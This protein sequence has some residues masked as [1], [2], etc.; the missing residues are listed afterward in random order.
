MSYFYVIGSNPYDNS[1]SWK[2]KGNGEWST[3]AENVDEALEYIFSSMPIPTE[4]T[5]RYEA[6][7][8]DGV[9]VSRL[10]SDE[11]IQVWSDDPLA[12]KNLPLL[13][14]AVEV[15]LIGHIPHTGAVDGDIC[16]LREIP[17]YEI[18]KWLHPERK[19]LAAPASQNTETKVLS[20]VG[21]TVR[22]FMATR[23][24]LA[25]DLTDKRL[26]LT[27]H[28]WNVEA[29]KETL[30]TQMKAMSEQIAL[31]ETYLHGAK[32]K[33]TV[34]K[35]PKGTGPYHIFQS[36]QFLNKEIALLANMTD[37]DFTDMEKLDAWLVSSG[38]LWSFLP[39]ERTLLVTR[40]RDKNKDYGCPWIN[41]SMQEA[42]M[43]SIIW[44]RD[45]KNVYRVSVENDF[46]NC[47]F[48]DGSEAEKLISTVTND[49]FAQIFEKSTKDWR[50]DPI[51]EEPFCTIKRD[52]L[53]ESEP[54][55]TKTVSPRRFKTVDEWMDSTD[56]TQKIKTEI[57]TSCIAALTRVNRCRMKFVL[58]LQ[59]L[60]DNTTFL[61]IPKGT[62]LF[63]WQSA[64]AYFVLHNDY[65]HALP[66]GHTRDLIDAA[67]RPD[68]LR[69]GMFIIASADAIEKRHRERSNYWIERR[70]RFYRVHKIVGDK[71]F[72]KHHFQSKHYPNN[73]V[74]A[75]KL[76]EVP[77]SKFVRAS[78][79]PDVA[80][81]ML[82]DRDW[83]LD[84]L[85]LV[86]LLAQWASVQTQYATAKHFDKVRIKNA[87]DDDE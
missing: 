16:L 59:G 42:N 80:E 50:G 3:N 87:G 24:E 62:N 51:T 44:I 66:D 71:V 23:H 9:S 29:Q 84:N 53:N 48:P 46:D 34:H 20:H 74:K 6:A 64:G 61:D 79:L 36:R 27:L 40:I 30:Q 76:I 81:R 15:G 86:P 38:K 85:A 19:L 82:A 4:L 13:E 31:A 47:V 83:K 35:G 57:S 41:W 26:E 68:Q 56:Y 55:V 39:F 21:V 5:G 49:V 72:V 32:S 75:A 63:D 22:D 77:L 28:K 33:V 78:L 8:I 58:L 25:R 18:E 54:Y 52:A 67:T 12:Q 7:F 73:P 1:H 70:W 43:M 60:V 45:G 10:S 69:V 37:F 65:T 2:E 17:V 11:V 14:K